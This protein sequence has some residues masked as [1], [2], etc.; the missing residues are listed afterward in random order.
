MIAWGEQGSRNKCRPVKDLCDARH[1]ASPHGA[2]TP[3]TI[4][5]ARMTGTLII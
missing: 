3:F 1:L 5:A 2:L 4:L